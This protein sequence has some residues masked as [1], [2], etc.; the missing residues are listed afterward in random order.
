MGF[1]RSVKSVVCDFV[2][3]GIRMAEDE[4]F[5]CPLLDLEESGGKSGS[6]QVCL[7]K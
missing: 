1:R 4:V 7:W 3:L 5:K 2:R 6:Y